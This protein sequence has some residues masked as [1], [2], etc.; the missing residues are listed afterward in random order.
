MPKKQSFV[1]GNKKYTVIKEFNS[2]KEAQ[3]AR[4]FII[5]KRGLKAHMWDLNPYV[6]VPDKRYEVATKKLKNGKTAVG[7]YHGFI[8]DSKGYVKRM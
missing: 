1:K 3:R 8:R 7:S 4:Q 2:Q 6:T 5:K